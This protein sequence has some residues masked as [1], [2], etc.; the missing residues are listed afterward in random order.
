[1]CATKGRFSIFNIENVTLKFGYNRFGSSEEIV[2]TLM[3]IALD[4]FATKLHLVVHRH[5]CPF[6][7]STLPL[8]LTL[9]KSGVC[10]MIS[11]QCNDQPASWWPVL[12]SSMVKNLNAAIF[13]DAIDLKT[14]KLCIIVL[15]TELY[16]FILLPVTLT[17]LQ[18]HSSVKSFNSKF[19][20][21]T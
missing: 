7:T 10:I 12:V 11:G 15:H 3:F 2:W 21:L 4:P 8:F 6:P 20:I 16:L 1:M 9:I 5:K 13:T 17:I 18:G 14:V 19:H